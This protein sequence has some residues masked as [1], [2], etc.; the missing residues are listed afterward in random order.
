[1]EERLPERAPTGPAIRHGLSIKQQT[2]LPVEPA[3]QDVRFIDR[4]LD[5]GITAAVA[6]AG[7]D[8]VTAS[9]LH[10]LEA[11]A[12]EYMTEFLEDTC[13][14]MLAARRN[15]PIPTD[16]VYALA[17][18]GITPSQLEDHMALPMPKELSCP[19]I[20]PP[21]PEEAPPIDLKPV[22]GNSLCEPAQVAYP[23]IPTHFPPLPSKHAW[24]HSAYVP[25]RETDPR[26]IRERATQE[27]IVAEK[28]LRK[29]AQAASNPRSRT[30]RTASKAEKEKQG[31]WQEALACLMADQSQGTQ[32]GMDGDLVMVDGTNEGKASKT[33]EMDDRAAMVVNYDRAYWRKGVS[34]GTARS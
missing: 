16:F 11:L 29:L 4:Q 28:S 31:L 19:V 21:A 3:S 5:K 18:G 2:P 13:M 15:A 25:P 23:Q 24:S 20:P 34:F 12:V 6:M 10:S 26:K 8:G 1:M 9:A 30:Q 33:A 7:F 32:D 22:L 27:G 14:S 17:R